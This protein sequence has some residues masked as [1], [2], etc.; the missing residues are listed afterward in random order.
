[1]TASVLQLKKP[2]GLWI[3]I[4]G[5][6]GSVGTR[7]PPSSC[8][9]RTGALKSVF[10]TASCVVSWLPYEIGVLS[11]LSQLR[12]AHSCTQTVP[13]SIPTAWLLDHQSPTPQSMWERSSK[14]APKQSTRWEIVGEEFTHHYLWNV[15][16]CL[17]YTS[18]NME[19]LRLIA[20]NPW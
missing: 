13:I 11:H 9:C 14:P 10:L 5:E 18:W 8:D 6:H 4:H 19:S 16:C 15:G 1:M 3:C 2:A 12:R 20:T 7:S 17:T